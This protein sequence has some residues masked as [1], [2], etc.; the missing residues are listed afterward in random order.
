[1]IEFN[2]RADSV[3]NFINRAKSSSDVDPDIKYLIHDLKVMV[4]NIENMINNEDMNCIEALQRLSD[5]AYDLDNLGRPIYD[6]WADYAY[7]KY[8]KMEDQ[9]TP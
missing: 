9:I 4:Y 2:K 6:K 5:A 8:Q 3:D 7:D 1:M